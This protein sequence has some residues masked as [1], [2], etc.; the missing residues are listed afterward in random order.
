MS[1]AYRLYEKSSKIHAFKRLQ[2][3]EL[4]IAVIEVMHNHIQ[5]PVGGGADGF[6]GAAADSWN[7]KGEEIFAILHLGK[8][9]SV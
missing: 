1:S 9:I 4:S 2:G 6:A 8:D 7:L 5:C 3:I